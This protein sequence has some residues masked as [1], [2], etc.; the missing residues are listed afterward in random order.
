MI[1]NAWKLEK[2]KGESVDI[3]EIFICLLRKKKSLTVMRKF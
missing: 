1:V 3:G 2:T